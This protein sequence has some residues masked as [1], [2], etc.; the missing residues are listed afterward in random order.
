M[1]LLSLVAFFTQKLIYSFKMFCLFQSST[2]SLSWLHGLQLPLPHFWPDQGFLLLKTEPRLLPAFSTTF[3]VNPIIDTVDLISLANRPPLDCSTNR[4]LT[5]LSLGGG[6]FCVSRFIW[7]AF[8]P[9]HL[10]LYLPRTDWGEVDIV[11]LNLF[12]GASPPHG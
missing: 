11:F 8:H 7:G 9:P 10:L 6:R 4:T 3:R 12:W 2:D 1:I 5:T